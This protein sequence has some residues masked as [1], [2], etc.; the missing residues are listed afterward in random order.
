VPVKVVSE[1]LGHGDV[2]ITLGVDQSVVP[3][4][5]ESAAQAMEDALS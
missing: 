2:A 3:D 4:M 1:M 5:Q